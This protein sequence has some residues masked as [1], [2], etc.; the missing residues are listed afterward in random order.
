MF[1]KL[2]T[3]YFLLAAICLLLMYLFPI[4]QIQ[5]EKGILDL[6]T[7]GIT[8]SIG[9]GMNTNRVLEIQL[10]IPLTSF[11]LLA[12]AFIFTKNKYQKAIGR[13]CYILILLLIFFCWFELYYVTN[14]L[15]EKEIVKGYRGFYFAVA[16]FAFVFLANRAIKREE[17][18]LKVL[19]QIRKK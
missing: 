11:F 18:I 9:E 12:S 8:Y 7:N 1:R 10:L 19:D 6:N 3:Y 17:E 15:L 16:S 4:A 13:L 2:Q 5:T 14:D